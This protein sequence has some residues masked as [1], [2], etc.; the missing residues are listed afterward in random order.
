MTLP[1]LF[2]TSLETSFLCSILDTFLTVLNQTTDPENDDRVRM[3]QFMAMFSKVPRFGT[4]VLFMS[5]EEKKLAK[6]V[7]EKVGV[8]NGCAAWGV[9]IG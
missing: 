8:Q 6:E 7:W 2:Q 3:R 1:A 4:V 9:N 5:V